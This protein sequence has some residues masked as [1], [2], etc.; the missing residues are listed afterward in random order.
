MTPEHNRRK[1]RNRKLVQEKLE[2]G[3]LWG[4]NALQ[5][6]WQEG[7]PWQSS[8]E[9]LALPLPGRHRLNPWLERK[10]QP[11]LSQGPGKAGM[12]AIASFGDY[13]VLYILP[14]RPTL[15]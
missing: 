6:M 14:I 1:F 13:K 5:R 7:L 10:F 3:F 8:D 4:G 11:A 15:K 9:D 2:S 12:G